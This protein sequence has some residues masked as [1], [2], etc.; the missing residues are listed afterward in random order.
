M[1]WVTMHV[2]PCVCVTLTVAPDQKCEGH[3]K[4]KSL[5]WFIY[6]GIALCSLWL[7]VEYQRLQQTRNKLVLQKKGKKK[8]G[9][10]KAT[11]AAVVQQAGGG[12]TAGCC[13]GLGGGCCWDRGLYHW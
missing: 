3:Q 4:G 10:E 13:Q 2:L 6:G 7:P 5:M 11:V 9:L 1:P 8:G 12:L